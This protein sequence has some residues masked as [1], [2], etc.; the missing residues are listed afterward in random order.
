MRATIIAKYNNIEFKSKSL[1]IDFSNISSS[2]LLEVE[3]KF[4]ENQGTES[5]I[6]WEI[7]SNGKQLDLGD[8]TT[9]KK[10]ELKLWKSY[11]GSKE[12]PHIFQVTAKDKDK[13]T[14]AQLQLNIF[15]KIAVKKAY[16]TDIDYNEIKEAGVNTEVKIQLDG[17]GLHDIPIDLEIIQILDSGEKS[18]LKKQIFTYDLQGD[19]TIYINSDPFDKGTFINI[20]N[21]IF[22]LDTGYIYFK[23]SYKN[24]LLFTGE[25]LTI[26]RYFVKKSDDFVETIKTVVVKDEQYFTQKY[27]PCKYEKI[28]YT[29]GND[30][31]KK[32]FDEDEPTKKGK[33][34]KLLN[35]RVEV[36]VI[37][38]PTDSKNIKDLIVRLEKVETKQCSLNESNKKYTSEPDEE[39]NSHAGNVINCTELDNAA[40]KWVPI[41]KDEEITIKPSFNYIYNGK[42][43]ESAWSFLKNYFL[44]SSVLSD[45]NPMQS[46]IKG[47]LMD[48]ESEFKG[49]VQTHRIGLNTCRYQKGLYLKTYADVAWAFHARFD[50]PFIPA[51]YNDNKSVVFVNGL[52]DEIDAL[53][54][55]PI[56]QNFAAPI[57]S[58]VIGGDFLLKFVADII[59]D[60]AERYELGFTA[61]YDF[62]ESGKNN[63]QQI[64]YAKTHPEFFKA[65]IAGV[66][67]LEIL[68][69]IILVIITEGAALA[70]F[71]SKASKVAKVV[72]KGAKVAENGMRAEQLLARHSKTFKAGRTAKGVKNTIELLKG[73]Y[74][75]AYRYIDDKD[76]GI[77]PLLEERVKISPLLLLTGV[78][79]EKNL[80]ELL[81]DKTPA[82]M[83][84]NLGKSLTGTTGL[85][86]SRI[87]LSKLSFT[88]GGKKIK[89]GEKGVGWVN[90]ALYPLKVVNGGLTL[91]YNLLAFASNEVITKIFGADGQFNKDIGAH[92]D[93]DFH[94]RILK[95][96]KKFD[97][98]QKKY[99]NVVPP[100]DKSSFHILP[101]G[102]FTV[103]IIFNGKVGEGVIVRA[104]ELLNYTKVREEEAESL[105]AKGGFKVEGNIIIERYYDYKGEDPYFEDRV[106]FL[107]LAGEYEYTIE[108]VDQGINS[109]KKKRRTIKEQEPK[110]FILM[111]PTQIVFN[112]SK[113]TKNPS[114]DK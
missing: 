8:L 50:G 33:D 49:I 58:P 70:N 86:M 59:K 95:A 26:R 20:V 23:L 28:F 102:A 61:Y 66:V 60:M 16:W 71:V 98:V 24:T 29:H 84:L 79:Q 11:A 35:S 47:A 108:A 5:V 44:F 82:G 69:D 31:E 39:Q 78:S 92:L 7:H 68:I 9:G 75:K 110:E 85:G 53:T 67:T 104:L 12:K 106:N 88:R 109:K 72:N 10:A 13:K 32:V 103:K 25:V 94:L 22:P 83:L 34:G 74:Y 105:E 63:S 40:I 81:L 18:L 54:S 112:S 15:D 64:D 30:E 113:L 62:D 99:G 57:L 56:T 41:I 6:Y 73:S 90:A 38:P 17:L 2:L 93:L 3:L 48:L 55:H 114:E 51:L 65:L 101:S 52:N 96:Q 107:G 1:D 21:T 36:S 43:P 87:F 89:V 46:S 77:Q 19:E 45:T 4:S 37:V 91:T 97:L 14:I 76:L 80:G 27:E 100:K 42:T 111:E